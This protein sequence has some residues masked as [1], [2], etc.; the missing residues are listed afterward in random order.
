MY[1]ELKELIENSLIFL[2][3]KT[4]YV[5]RTSGLYKYI[6]N[7]VDLSVTRDNQDKLS[8]NKNN[9]IQDTENDQP[10]LVGGLAPN[11]IPSIVNLNGETRI[12]EYT[13]IVVSEEDTYTIV[14]FIDTDDEDGGK[15]RLVIEE[16]SDVT[17]NELEFNGHIRFYAIFNRSLTT[18]EQNALLA[19]L[20]SIYSEIENVTIG[21]Q[22]WSSRNLEIVTT[23]QGNDIIEVDIPATWATLAETYATVY[24]ATEGSTAQKN[25][26]AL[27]AAAAWRYPDDDIDNGSWAGKIYNKYAMQLIALDMALANFGWHIPTEAEVNTL[28]T[29]V[30]NDGNDLKYSGTDYWN[31]DNGTN[32]S[33][34]TL[35]GIGIIREDGVY[36]GEKELSG[37]WTSDSGELN[38]IGLPI[39]LIKNA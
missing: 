4:A 22:V 5:L 16:V 39:R 30:S 2:D 3:V 13:D 34:L 27:I 26:A 32:E 31:D 38:T 24:A 23:P 8:L 6:S 33:G 7:W 28:L 21:T 20:Q 25:Y 1:Q 37:F 9:A 29:T 18:A 19:F 35:L 11:S 14:K 36:V 15:Y 12:F 10:R 17:L